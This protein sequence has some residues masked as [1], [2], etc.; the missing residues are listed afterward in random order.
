MYIFVKAG[1]RHDKW[2]AV[3]VGAKEVERALVPFTFRDAW[4]KFDDPIDLYAYYNLVL[5]N[6]EL[7][8]LQV[9]LMTT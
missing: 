7:N 6:W 4:M 9:C 3:F 5:E 1:R 2:R 8:R